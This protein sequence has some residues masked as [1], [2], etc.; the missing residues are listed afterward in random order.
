MMVDLH[1]E[2]S[3]FKSVIAV[4]NQ[5]GAI[6]LSIVVRETGWGPNIWTGPEA[7]CTAKSM[8]Q[9]WLIDKSRVGSSSI[10]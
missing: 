8:L 7:A 3:Q 2:V 1:K 5:R 9:I 4:Y 10:L 6:T